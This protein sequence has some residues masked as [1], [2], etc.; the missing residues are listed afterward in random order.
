MRSQEIVVEFVGPDGVER[1]G[2]LIA[3]LLEVPGV[4][5]VRINRHEGRAIVTGD[6]ELAVPAALFEAVV[7]AGYEPGDV[8]F[9][10]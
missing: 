8:W 6:T 4:H 1:E 2:E 10:E 9:A 7:R 5:E 3:A